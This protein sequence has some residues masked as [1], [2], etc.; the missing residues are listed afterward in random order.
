MS[1]NSDDGINKICRMRA[2][3][4][5]GLFSKSRLDHFVFIE[6]SKPRFISPTP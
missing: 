1:L 4:I 3:A 5:G 6:E 2:R